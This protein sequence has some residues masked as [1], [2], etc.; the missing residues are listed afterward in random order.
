MKQKAGIFFDNGVESCRGFPFPQSPSWMLNLE[1]C[2][3]FS[4]W[5]SE[6]CC[7]FSC[8]WLSTLLPF[9]SPQGCLQML[10]G[11][12]KNIPLKPPPFFLKLLVLAS[13]HPSPNPSLQP[14]P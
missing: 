11:L 9:I 1:H 4:A 5:Y 12:H 13:S 6:T 14:L 10:S 3:E 7:L 8:L 2:I